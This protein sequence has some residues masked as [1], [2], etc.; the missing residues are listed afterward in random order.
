MIPDMRLRGIVGREARKAPRILAVPVLLLSA[1]L[2]GCDKV[3]LLA[4][5]GTTIR[6]YTSTQVLP[7]NGTAQITASVQEVGG[8]PVQNGTVVT[9]T[10]SLGSVT[11][12]EATTTD[13]KVTVTFLAGSQSGTA[14][15]NAFSGSSSTTGGSTAGTGGNGGTTGTT[16]TTGSGVSIVIGAAAAT[17][18]I[19]TASPSSVSQLGGTSTITAAV[20]D[21]NNNGLAGVPVAFTTDQGTVSPVTAVTNGNG[22]ATTMLSTNQTATVTITAG[23]KTATAKVTAVAVPTL[24]LTGPTTTPTVGVV[25]TFTVNAAAGSGSAPIRT[26]TVDFGDGK[27]ANLGA[28]NGSVTVPHVYTAPGVYTVTAIATDASGQGTSMSIPV[29]VFAAVPFTLT[30]TA[31]S[32]RVGTAI[33]ANAVPAAGAPTIDKY[34]WNW[35]DGTIEETATSSH[36][37]V[38]TSIPAGFSSWTYTIT[39][40]AKGS[41]GREGFGSTSVIIQSSGTALTIR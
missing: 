22:M 8:W 13:G 2:A 28:A 16:G 29:V 38:Y 31:S 26:V 5:S 19:A 34:I 30:V 11:P 10:T 39:V 6:L 1:L 20:L 40:T 36:S 4:P 21:A 32:G 7:I 41:D 12:N 35:G 37:H 14:V 24:T 17:T 9:F 25:A 33:T 23:T 27:S 18:V 15:I 3:P